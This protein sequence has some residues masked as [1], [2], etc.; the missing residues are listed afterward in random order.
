MAPEGL[1]HYTHNN[2]P[3][4]AAYG[5]LGIGYSI[6][7]ELDTYSPA[8]YNQFYNNGVNSLGNN[9]ELLD[10]HS[11]ITIQICPIG[12]SFGGKLRGFAELGFG[13]KG[14]FNGGLSLKL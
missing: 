13:Y 5:Y 12:I 8:Y 7:N 10:N 4:I 1:F 14:I 2:N 9:R 11:E 6:L 3:V